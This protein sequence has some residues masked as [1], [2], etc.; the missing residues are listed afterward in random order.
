MSTAS[1]LRLVEPANGHRSTAA[2][3]G[4]VSTYEALRL[5][6]L[7]EIAQ[8]NIDGRDR[9]AVTTLV[10]AHVER[11]QRSAETGSGRRFANPDDVVERLVRSVVGAGPF[12]KFFVQPGPRRRGQLQEGRDHLLHP[13]RA[14]GRRHRADERGRAD[15]RLSAPAR[16]GRRWRSTSSIRSSCTRCG[17]TGCALSVS[18][19]PVADCLD[20]TFRI[21]RPHR[22][23]LVD[24]VELGSLSRP[25]GERCRGVPARSNRSAGHGRSR[26]RQV[27]VRRGAPAGDAGDDDHAD[28][29]G[30]PRARRAA[31]SRRALVARGRRPHDPLARAALAAVRP[32]AA[33]RRRD[34]G[35]GGVRAAEG[36]QRRVRFP[37]N[38]ARQLGAARDA[39]AGHGG[40]DGRRERPR[41]RRARDVRPADRPR[42]PLRGRAA[43]PGR[44]RRRRRRQV[45]EI[46]R[47]A[48]ADLQRRV[49]ARADVRPRGLRPSARVRR[50]P[51][52][53]RPRTPTRSCAAAGRDDARPGRGM[54]R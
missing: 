31:P 3:D 40:V 54:R 26:Q 29:A 6:V 35:R 13:R 21:Y 25:G 30:R 49:R 51:P 32:A 9:G 24:L 48:A 17:A 33:R 43:A 18:I 38:P 4:A 28:R 20:G 7:E 53:R 41:T 19:P 46:S 8:S 23:D 1:N 39:V 14:P 2:D 37:D 16:R 50:P 42:H 34:P 11:H 10:R 44:S 27:D 52:A 45:M 36:R 12:E 47:G 22:T 5:A 15:R